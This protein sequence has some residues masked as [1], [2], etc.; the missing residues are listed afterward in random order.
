MRGQRVKIDSPRRAVECG[1]AY[2]PEDR[3]RHGVIPKLPISANLTLAMLDRLS[4]SVG[5]DFRQEKQIAAD[6]VLRLGIKTPAIFVPIATLSGGNQQKVALG[7]W[8]VTKPSV[9]ILDEPT[10]G[11]DVAARSEIYRLMIELADQGVAILMISSDLTEILG[12]SDRIGVMCGG[13]IAGIFDRNEATQEKI[14][15]LALGGIHH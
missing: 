6:Y 3:Q 12:M 5:M 11:I 15:A 7:R 8:L 9:L 2:V 13:T 1:I 14:L 10:Q 4:N